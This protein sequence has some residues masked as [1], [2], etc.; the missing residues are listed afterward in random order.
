MGKLK[1]L[2]GTTATYELP[3]LITASTQSQFSLTEPISL[4]DLSPYTQFSDTDGSS[5]SKM[6]AFDNSYNTHYN[7]ANAACHVG[8]DFGTSIKAS[9]SRIRFFPQIS[10][11]QV[12]DHL[13]DAKF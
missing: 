5:S 7:S 2:A 4:I 13:L 11:T 3:S 1:S 9:V 8:V 10:W 6:N 12:I